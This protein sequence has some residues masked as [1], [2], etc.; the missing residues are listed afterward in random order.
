MDPYDVKQ[1][2]QILKQKSIPVKEV[3][4]KAHQFCQEMHIM[5]K[6]IGKCVWNAST[7][8]FGFVLFSGMELSLTILRSSEIME[9]ILGFV[10]GILLSSISQKLKG[11]KKLMDWKTR[12]GVIGLARSER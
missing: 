1:M 8:A 11:T 6:V 12:T 7:R 4:M 5:S 2:D 3:P 10:V 9:R